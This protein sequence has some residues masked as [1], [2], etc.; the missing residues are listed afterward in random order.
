MICLI[1]HTLPLFIINRKNWRITVKLHFENLSIFLK[2]ANVYT[3]AKTPSPCSFLFTFQGPLP[4]PYS[5]N[6]LFECPI[7]LK[8]VKV[9]D[10]KGNGRKMGHP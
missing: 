1:F 10:K 6:V 2:K 4:L 8:L 5:M 9:A 7:T 3:H